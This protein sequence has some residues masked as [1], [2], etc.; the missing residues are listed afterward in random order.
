MEYEQF[1]PAESCRR[2]VHHWCSASV[3][4]ASCSIR[5]VRKPGHDPSSAPW[6]DP[7]LRHRLSALVVHG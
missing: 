3:P 7:E 5:T 1:V 4:Y 6:S 2:S